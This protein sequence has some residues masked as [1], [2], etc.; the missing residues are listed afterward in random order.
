MCSAVPGEVDEADQGAGFVAGGEPAETVAVETGAPVVGAWRVAEGFGVKA[1]EL[2]VVE[3]A[4]PGVGD[5]GGQGRR[6]I[7]VKP[8]PPA[9]PAPGKSGASSPW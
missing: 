4:A 6:L 1:L 5:G 9:R 8:P 2:L 7:R 3:R